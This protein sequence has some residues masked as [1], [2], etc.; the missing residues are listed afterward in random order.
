MLWIH[1][2]AR[3]ADVPLLR[4]PQVVVPEYGFEAYTHLV[5]PNTTSPFKFDPG[6]GELV[7]K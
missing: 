7:A 3:D 6:R 1:P 4:C 5:A 2:P